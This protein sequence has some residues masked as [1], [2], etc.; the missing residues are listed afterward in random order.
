MSITP[1]E[2]KTKVI[3]SD[4]ASTLRENQKAHEAGEAAHAAQNQQR[5]QQK[6]QTVQNTQATEHKAIRKQDEEAEKEKGPPDQPPRK[7]GESAAEQPGD[8]NDQKTTKPVSDGVRGISIDV[9]A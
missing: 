9:K 2:T 1:L 4:N 7:R 3:A 5:D 8:E 6:A